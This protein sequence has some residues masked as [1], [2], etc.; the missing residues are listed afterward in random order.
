VLVHHDT[1]PQT[2]FSAEAA[3]ALFKEARR[4]TRRRRLRRGFA[5]AVVLGA[6]AVAYLASGGGHSG[7]VAESARTPFVN[8]KAF[9][10]GGELAFISRGSLWVLDG[11]AGSLRRMPVPRGFSPASPIFSR[12]GN[13]LAY[14]VSRESNEGAVT[15]ELWLARANGRTAHRVRGLVV[16]AL[17]GWSPS[18]DVLAVT[19]D[20]QRPIVYTDGTRGV[21][22][23]TTVVQVVTPSGAVR[24]L[25]ALP[26][27]AP[28]FSG[29]EDAVW[30]PTGHAIAVSTFD[31]VPS[32]GTVVR[33]YPVDGAAPTTWFSIG[34]R[35]RVVGV[36][37]QACLGAIADLAG[38]WPKWG[39]GFWV[40]A[41]G[42]THNSDSTPLELLTAPRAAPRLIAQTLSDGT[43]DAVA[44]GAGGALAVVASSA[45]PGRVYTQGKTVENC[46]G[47]TLSCVPLPRA[48]IWAAADPEARCPSVCR[49]PNTPKPGAPG[50]GVS[51]DPAWSP[52]GTLLAYVKAPATIEAQAPAAWYAAHELFVWNRNT[53]TTR[54]IADIAGVSLPTWSRNGKQLLYVSND[55]LWLAPLNSRPIEIEY[56]LFPAREWR[57]VATNGLSFY[58]QINWAGRFN[59]WS[60]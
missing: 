41:G 38:W 19:T 2:A 43:T 22:Q 45:G 53:N 56:P 26:T 46:S 34:S 59:W 54:K 31:G 24:R 16:P 10:D 21:V 4:R 11:A 55:G 52:D 32:G 18:G 8:V 6:A 27:S 15:S 47:R 28:T 14:V 35:Q 23:R 7:V 44:S 60:P 48:S 9:N 3:E 17:V 57:A 51:L 33:S 50:S 58:G 30:S 49:Q 37:A 12:D 40:F 13:W 1:D 36:C 5:I 29:I 39:I 42:M 20:T 25:V